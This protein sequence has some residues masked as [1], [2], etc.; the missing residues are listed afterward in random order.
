MSA[1][2]AEAERALDR[3]DFALGRKLARAHFGDADAAAQQKAHALF[4]RTTPDPLIVWLSFACVA[5]FIAVV[6]FGTR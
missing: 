6:Y 5:F 4:E 2:L 1:P 3:G